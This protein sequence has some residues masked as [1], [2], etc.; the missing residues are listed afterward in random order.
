MSW[1]AKLFAKSTPKPHRSL[2][3]DLNSQAHAAAHIQQ[4]HELLQRTVAETLKANGIPAEWVKLE[5]V[6]LGAEHQAQY[7]LQM[8]LQQWEPFLLMHIQALEQQIHLRLR[9]KSAP[10]AQSLR[11]VL[12]R[13]GDT[14]GCPYQKMP[15]AST[16]SPMAVAQR[17]SNFDAVMQQNLKP[18]SRA[19][20]LLEEERDFNSTMPDHLHS[21][22][23]MSDFAE[24][25][26]LSR[27]DPQT[28]A[29]LERLEAHRQQRQTPS[30]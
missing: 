10:I 7:Q 18:N 26:Q 3:T 8:S 28:R 21:A 12:W 23:G 20:R 9:S 6:T 27:D 16:W 1:F 25:M 2:A 13:L 24:T 5:V 14:A 17:R 19:S 22:A 11:A 29:A 4:A 30:R 15:E